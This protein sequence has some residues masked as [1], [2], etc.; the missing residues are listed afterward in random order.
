MIDFLSKDSLIYRGN[1]KFGTSV[2]LNN[3]FTESAQL[4]NNISTPVFFIQ[5]LKDEFVSPQGNLKY[6]NESNQND[7]VVIE[8]N[9][10]EHDIPHDRRIIR[11]MEDIITWMKEH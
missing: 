3:L 6:L 4:K 8:V 5:G 2:A 10:L 9:D 7:K 11:Y 1:F